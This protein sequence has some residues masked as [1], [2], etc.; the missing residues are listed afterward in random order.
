MGTVGGDR[1]V[2]DPAE[3][4]ED[5]APGALTAA[6]T[7]DVLLEGLSAENRTIVGYVAKTLDKLTVYKTFMDLKGG[8]KAAYNENTGYILRDGWA[9]QITTHIWGKLGRTTESFDPA[10]ITCWCVLIYFPGLRPWTS[11]E[12][13]GRRRRSPQKNGV[14]STTPGNPRR[15]CSVCPPAPCR[16]TRGHPIIVSARCFAYRSVCPPKPR[17]TMKLSH[18]GRHYRSGSHVTFRASRTVPKTRPS[19]SRTFISVD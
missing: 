10:S 8:F 4:D 14:L 18:T 6:L 5:D 3:S 19:R 17:G 11:F 16:V 15:R 1:V 2:N 13:H 12:F 7:F 9:E